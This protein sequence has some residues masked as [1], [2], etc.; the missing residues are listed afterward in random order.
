MIGEEL[1]LKPPKYLTV[2]VLGLYVPAK[3]GIEDNI[4]GLIAHVDHLGRFFFF[5]KYQTGKERLP[6]IR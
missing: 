1:L 4:M 3:V 5:I 2:Y 6:A